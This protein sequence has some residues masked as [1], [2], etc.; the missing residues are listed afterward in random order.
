MA[1]QKIFLNLAVKDLQKSKEFFKSLG[2][3]IEESI[4][5]DTAACVVISEDI[6]LMLLTEK[7]FLEFTPKQISDSTKTTEV[8]TCL[9][10]ESREKVDELV[11]K[12]I[13]AGAVE[14]TRTQQFPTMYY[15]SFSDLDG[16]IWEIMWMDPSVMNSSKE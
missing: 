14:N 8:M 10:A 9:S 13:A 5:D 4:T 12:A 16:H 7:K 3:N 11:D 6:Y 15:R 1:A 2:Y